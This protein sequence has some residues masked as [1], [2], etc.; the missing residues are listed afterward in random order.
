MLLTFSVL[1]AASCAGSTKANPTSAPTDDR[2]TVSADRVDP[3][4]DVEG[5]FDLE[6]AQELRADDYGMG[7]YVIAFLKAGPNRERTKD[8][9][10]ALQKQHM[11][12]IQRLA[13][14]GVLV[15]AGPFMDNGELRGIYVF[16]VKDVEEA[17]RLTE[18]DPA[19]QA[20]SLTLE[21]HPWYGSAALR[22]VNTV[23]EQIAKIKM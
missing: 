19:V 17:R 15:L 2:A 14:E 1:T 23:H 20:G 8:E 5:G 7:Q 16:D 4:E 6:L 11:A 22:H 13:D 9:A 18:T 21:L 3:S 10:I 12:N